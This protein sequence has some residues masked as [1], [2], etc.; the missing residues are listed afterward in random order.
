MTTD[1]TACQ[2]ETV[3]RL[4]AKVSRGLPPVADW[5]RGDPAPRLPAGSCCLATDLRPPA[6]RAPSNTFTPV[7][8]RLHRL[9]T[10]SAASASTSRA[11]F[12]H[13][14]HEL[15]QVLLQVSV[16]LLEV[17]AGRSQRRK[18][19]CCKSNLE[20]LNLGRTAFWGSRKQVDEVGLLT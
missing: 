18:E 4:A 14:Q 11:R 6:R 20:P 17:S 13:E 15:S 16:F 19:S 8:R 1:P 10:P 2:S 9:T 7:K 12:T 5:M 3:R